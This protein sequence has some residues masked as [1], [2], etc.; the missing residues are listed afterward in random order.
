MKATTGW[1]LAPPPHALDQWARRLRNGR[2][3]APPGAWPAVVFRAATV[4]SDSHVPGTRGPPATDSRRQHRH[5]YDDGDGEQAA[6]ISVTPKESG[7]GS[8]LDQDVKDAELTKK[9][10]RFSADTVDKHVI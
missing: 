6:G 3:T 4:S 7:S 2:Q 9:R 1:R 8:S 5:I 10:A